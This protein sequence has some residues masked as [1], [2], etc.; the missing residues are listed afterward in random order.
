MNPLH[1]QIIPA[2]LDD[3]PTIQNMARFYLY[4]MTRYCATI[5]DEWNMPADGLYECLDFKSYFT[6]PTRKAFFVKVGEALAG[7]VLLDKKGTS[8]DTTWNMGEFFIIAQFQE[9]GISQR[10][11]H[12]IWKMHPGSWEVSV[13]PENIK[14]LGFWRKGIARF[15]HDEYIE[16]IKKID[17][18]KDQPNRYIFTFMA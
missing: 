1:P 4:D 3:Y 9:K 18:D 17:Y 13:I 2:T 15:T 7:F 16:E 5:S 8:K 10:V 14:A 6:D 12:E 11:A